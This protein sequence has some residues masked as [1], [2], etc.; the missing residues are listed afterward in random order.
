MYTE[1]LITEL[2]DDDKVNEEVAYAPLGYQYYSEPTIL[3]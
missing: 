2:S 1:V 3:L